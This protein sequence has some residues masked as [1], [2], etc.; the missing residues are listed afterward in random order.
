MTPKATTDAD[1]AYFLAHPLTSPLLRDKSY[2]QIPG[3]SALHHDPFFRRA[4]RTNSAVLKSA[5]IFRALPNPEGHL[6]L[7]VGHGVCGQS[8]VAH[9]GFL[10]TVMDEVSGNLI[11]SARLDEGLGMYTAALNMGYKRPVLVEGYDLVTGEGNGD[12]RGS[13]VTATARLGR[14]EGRKV[15][16]AAEIRDESGELCTT[17]EL[18][19]VKKKPVL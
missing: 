8:G 16:M 19:F 12:G 13:V 18:V 2:T 1:S 6:F 10:A 4:A 5:F 14:V 15:F 9:G 11:A 3:G 7:Q 17:A